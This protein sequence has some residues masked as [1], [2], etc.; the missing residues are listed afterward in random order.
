M[1]APSVQAARASA[2][3][4]LR[5]DEGELALQALRVTGGNVV[6][7]ATVLGLSHRTLCRWLARSPELRAALALI[8]ASR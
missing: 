1:T 7:A 3:A 5:A 2:K 6:Q 8:R 4:K